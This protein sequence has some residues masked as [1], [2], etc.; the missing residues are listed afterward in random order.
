MSNILDVV[1]EH[2][3]LTETATAFKGLCPFHVEKTPSFHVNTKGGYFHCFGCGAVGDAEEFLERTAA[4]KVV[5]CH[6]QV[7]P[8]RVLPLL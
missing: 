6:G 4:L 8:I 3:P 1:R 7:D 5:D 2:V